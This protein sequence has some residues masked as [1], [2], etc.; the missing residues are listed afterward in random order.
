[1]GRAWLRRCLFPSQEVTLWLAPYLGL[2]PREAEDDGGEFS[3]SPR[4][5]PGSPG[6]CPG[7]Q[8]H[9][10]T[11][12]Q[13]NRS[14]R[15][16]PAAHRQGGALPRQPARSPNQVETPGLVTELNPDSKAARGP[17]LPGQLCGSPAWEA[18]GEGRS[19]PECLPYTPLS[20]SCEPWL[21]GSLSSPSRLSFSP[22]KS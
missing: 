8:Q 14:G 13:A 1:M 12:E 17:S 21:W 4:P 3:A 22:V 6:L 16:Q 18:R 10:R 19:G 15:G 7:D 2:R 11:L 20:P 9:H 5:P